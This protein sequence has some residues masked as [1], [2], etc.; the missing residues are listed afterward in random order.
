WLTEFISLSTAIKRAHG[1]YNRSFLLTETDGGDLTYFILNQLELLKK[2]IEDL[3]SY[4]S[5]KAQE[6]LVAERLMK[7]AAFLNGRQRAFL[8]RALRHPGMNQ[9]VRAYQ[10]DNGVV[11]ET[12]RTDLLSLADAGLLHKRKIGK[13]FTFEVP[14]DLE[15]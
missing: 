3:N 6:V 10:V 5:R 9:T 1:Q 15:E 13:A 2:A 8:S 4:L 7:G 12:A 14:T 11:Y